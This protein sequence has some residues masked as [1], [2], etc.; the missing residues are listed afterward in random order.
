M[1][2][3]VAVEPERRILIALYLSETRNILIAYSFLSTL[4]RRGVRHVI[5][6]GAKWYPVAARWARLEHSIVH[7]GVRSYVERFICTVKDRLRGFD[8]YF[9]SPRKLLDSALRLIYA[10]ACFYNYA[11]V[12]LSFGEPPHPMPGST[13]LERLKALVTRG[14]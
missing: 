8:A 10:W 4:K 5:T 11:R 13:E 1:W 9:P 2:L 3:W 6:D 12:H 7:G 14:D